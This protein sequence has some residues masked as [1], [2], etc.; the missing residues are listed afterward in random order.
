MGN[1]VLLDDLTINK[2]VAGEVIERP[3]NKIKNIEDLENNY[4]MGFRGEAMASIASISKLI[5]ASKTK[6]MLSGTKIVAK[7]GEIQEKEEITRDITRD[8]DY[9]YIG[10]LLKTYII[11]EIDEE[12]YLIDQHA[13]HERILYE[14]IKN[15]YKNN[16]SRNCQMVLIP[17]VESL[18]YKEMEFV[19]QNIEL[20]KN[21]GFEIDIFGENS[22]KINGIPDLEY[23]GKSKNIFLD[24]L[25]EMVSNERTSI[26]DV[27]ERFIATVACKAAVKAGMDLEKAEV[28]NLIKNLLSLKNPYTC[29]HGRPTTIKIFKKM[30]DKR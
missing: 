23:K 20:F 12:L 30:I 6:N 11:V 25:D 17:E 10:I 26:K 24:I 13:A 9:K 19:R 22:V 5:L 7:A 16:I 15:N 2:I 4:T 29:P 3:A 1:I 21:T 27:E 8:V 14:Q 28:D 18:T